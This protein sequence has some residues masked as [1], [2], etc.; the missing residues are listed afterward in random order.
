MNNSFDNRLPKTTTYWI[1]DEFFFIKNT[2]FFI[3]EEETKTLIE[4]LTFAMRDPKT[5]GVVVDNR[6]TS[7][8]WPKEIHQMFDNSSSSGFEISRKKIATLTNSIFRSGQT[9]R[10]S[11]EY[12]IE[13]TSKTFV[14]DFNDEVKAFLLS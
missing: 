9:N 11:K 8:A 5:K 14:T 13:E 12:G 7:G 3:S 6:E 2:N 1:D 4:L 10:L